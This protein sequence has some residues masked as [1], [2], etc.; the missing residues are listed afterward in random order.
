[1]QAPVSQDVIDD[2]AK[3]G[4]TPE[5]IGARMAQ[6]VE[7][8][9][10]GISASSAGYVIPYFDLWG[11]NRSFYRVK[12]F[13]AN[14]KYRQP[15]N[16]SNNIY[17][18]K[19][20]QKCLK[21]SGLKYILICEGEKKAA[22]AVAHGIPAVA[23]GGVDSW[24]NRTF[25][26]PEGTELGKSY[27]AKDVNA[28][29]PSGVDNIGESGLTTMA[30]GFAE[31]SDFAK[32][33]DFHLIICYDTDEQDGVKYEVQR[34]AASLAYE[35]RHRGIPF[36]HLHQLV[37]PSM[38]TLDKVGVDDFLVHV[39]VE[40]F[41]RHI[42][43]M[44]AS[45]SSFPQHPNPT[46][47]VNRKLQKTK[48]TRKEAQAAAMAVLADLDCNGKRLYSEAEKQLYYFDRKKLR[49]MSVAFND[50]AKGTMHGKEFGQ[51]LYKRYGLSAADGRVLTWL[52]IQMSAEEPIE[53]VNPHRIIARPEKGENVIRYQISDGQY[54]KVDGN[55]ADGEDAITI[56]NNGDEGYLFESGHVDAIDPDELL[57]EIERQRHIPMK[58][59]WEDVLS[60]VRLKSDDKNRALISLL[61]YI[62]PWLYKWRGA[63]LP[64]ELVIGES[65]S[66]K[67][68][69]C[70]HRLNI[71]TGSS[72]LRNA[73][74][75]LKS[76]HASISNVGGL[77][78]TDNVNLVD[79]GLRQRLSDEICRL[80]T[81]PDPHVEMRKLYSNNELIRIPARVVFCLTAIQQ[82]FMQA[83]L[84][85]RAV[86]VELDKN[87]SSSD[88]GEITYEY[89][90]VT[91][92]M[93]RFGGRTAWL[94][95]HLLVL[96][97]FFAL[98][99]EHW[100]P[101]YKAAHR[102]INLE[103]ALILIAKVFEQDGSWIPEFMSSSANKHISEADWA[104]E[105]LQE[106]AEAWKKQN[107]D[108]RFAASHI[109]DW[110]KSNEEYEE[111]YQLT[112]VRKL[113][114]YMSTS[115]QMV[116]ELT[117]IVMGHK[118][119][120]KQMFFVE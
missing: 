10:L 8:G 113:G 88:D 2:L 15:K 27:N 114:R 12:L 120:N 109:A 38:K 52:D 116:R 37:L 57:A 94:A 51:L 68:S 91:D 97:R 112:N 103:Q 33:N 48:M 85:Q 24:K 46:E 96:K 72:E 40:A 28:K 95:H 87:A 5:D 59:W 31:L 76:W 50:G 44:L 92:Q 18:P 14:V 1:M 6:T 115:A 65:G 110:A 79:K 36:S 104:L 17:F 60:T 86:L 56:L 42:D 117:H 98:V 25:I 4:I 47:Y 75:D 7:F 19:G 78:V 29:I 61:Y 23:L 35:L 84:L 101:R 102:L 69:L 53:P 62:S 118:Q 11:K 30:V 26:L 34:A 107:G 77:H 90:W 111:C 93:A 80:V 106:F 70:E 22:S 63:Q 99:D 74:A 21:T 39:G 32:V 16:T 41:K 81:E 58:S 82:P 3:S 49:L 9:A 108:K 67:S 119:A 83:D 100:N 45:P 66:G 89:N 55:P 13:N 43:N 105:G 73:P 64:V 71:I 54:V 20:L